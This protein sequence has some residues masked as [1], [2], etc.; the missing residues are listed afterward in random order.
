V[1]TVL[2]LFLCLRQSLYLNQLLTLNQLRS[3]NESA[4]THYLGI[5][6][7]AEH[8]LT[9]PV[10]FV[11][12]LE[13]GDWIQKQIIAPEDS[14]GEAAQ[15]AALETIHAPYAY[16]EYV[17]TD[18]NSFYNWARWAFYSQSQFEAYFAYHGYRI[19]TLEGIG[20][21]DILYYEDYAHSIGMKP[22]EILESDDLILVYLG[23]NP[24]PGWTA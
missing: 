12:K 17:M 5:R 18:V 23:D 6:L 7:T 16:K 19:H 22:F 24:I 1:V 2:L 10:V 21:N 15:R 8:D 4:I 11:G 20:Y 13:L 3:E 9:K 14:L